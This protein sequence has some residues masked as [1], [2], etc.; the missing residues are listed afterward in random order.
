MTV[1]APP[2]TG[3]GVDIVGLGRVADALERWGPTYLGRLL[4]P[5]E[6]AWWPTGE[7]RPVAA[8]IGLKEAAYKAASQR[9]GRPGWHDV[10]LTG[11]LPA[12]AADPTL[13][14]LLLE[15][16]AALAATPLGYVRARVTVAATVVV[17]DAGWAATDDLVVAC[18]VARLP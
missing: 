11:P 6:R 15:P 10:E 18:A 17:V 7:A 1:T 5:T 14:E 9:V 13:R 3:I 2:L 4:T 16:A 8:A 12:A